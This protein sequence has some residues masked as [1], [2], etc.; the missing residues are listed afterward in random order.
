M[1]KILS[2]KNGAGHTIKAKKAVRKIEA[3][4]QDALKLSCKGHEEQ[5]IIAKRILE[6]K[7]AM[8]SE[9]IREIEREKM[10]TNL[11]GIAA[12]RVKKAEGVY[13]VIV[14]DPPWNMKKIEL[15]ATPEQVGFNYPTMTEAE[16]SELKIPAADNCHLWIWTPQRFLPSALRLLEAWRFKY[17][18]TFVWHKPDGIQPFRLPKFNCE[19]AIYARKGT[20]QFVDT[21]NFFTCFNA[22]RGKHSEKPEAFYEFVRRVTA[23]RRIDMFNRRKIKGFDTWGNEAK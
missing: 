11:E 8:V 10:R 15:D 22:P 19:F 1:G 5:E 21:K 2:V 6:G 23:G 20:P 17:S 14:I 13:D 4:K 12:Q 9:A 18:C 3:T 7:A 16:L